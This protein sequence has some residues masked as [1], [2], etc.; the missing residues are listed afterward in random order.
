MRFWSRTSLYSKRSPAL[1]PCSRNLLVLSCLHHLDAPDWQ[2]GGVAFWRVSHNTYQ[3]AIHC[4]TGAR[5]SRRLSTY[6]M[7]GIVP[8]LRCGGRKKQTFSWGSLWSRERGNCKMG[9]AP[10]GGNEAQ[11]ERGRRHRSW[12]ARYTHPSGS[13]F[14][15]L[16]KA[17]FPPR[18]SSFKN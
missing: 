4:R 10:V 17:S 6:Y 9:G 13:F 16:Q 2:N 7:P 3:V 11:G 14:F 12:G 1:G 5:F 18:H 8:D 15:W